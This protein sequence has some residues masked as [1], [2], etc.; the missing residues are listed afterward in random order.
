[1]L[2]ASGATGGGTIL[3][4]GDYQ[5]GGTLARALNVTVDANSVMRADALRSA[6][7]AARSS[8]GPTSSRASR[9]RSARAAVRTAATAAAEV[10]GK[11]K[12]SYTGFTDLRAAKGAFGTCCSTPTTSRSRMVPTPIE[13]LHANADDSVINITHAGDRPRRRQRHRLHRFW[14]WQPRRRYH[15]R[16]LIQLVDHQHADAERVPPHRL[17]C[18]R[19]GLQ[20]RRRR[21]GA[22]RQHRAPARDGLF[23]SAGQVNFSAGGAVSI[24]AIRLPIPRRRTSPATSRSAAARR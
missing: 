5:G 20:Q 12:L 6:A 17:Q 9:A 16:R 22:R 11:E 13:Q 1:M 19:R 14:R 15:Y 8:S 7:T 10:S 3:I 2:D 18:R 21:S 24:F 4:G 23:A